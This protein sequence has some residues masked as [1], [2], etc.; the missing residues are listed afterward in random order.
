MEVVYESTTALSCKRVL[1]RVC[2][3]EDGID[4]GKFGGCRICATECRP[5]V[6]DHTCSNNVTA[7]VNRTSAHRNLHKRR[8]S[9]ELSNRTKWVDKATLIGDNAITTNKGLTSDRCLE[10]FHTKHVL[11]NFLSPD[12]DLR[13]N[14]CHVIIAGNHVA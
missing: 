9:I 14:K 5:I 4:D 2:Q 11:N 3:L 8:N 6:H 10:R 1:T 7:T 12:V 13:V